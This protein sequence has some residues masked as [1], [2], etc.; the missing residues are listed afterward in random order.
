[1]RFAAQ[2]LGGTTASVTDLDAQRWTAGATEIERRLRAGLS[3]LPPRTLAH[4]WVFL[5]G[6]VLHALTDREAFIASGGA[7]RPDDRDSFLA[8]LVDA[9]VALVTAPVSDG[10]AELLRGNRCGNR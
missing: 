3:G 2:A 4:R 9:S 1:M 10:T 7:E 5:V 6:F 8:D